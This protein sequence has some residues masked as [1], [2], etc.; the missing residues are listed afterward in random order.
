MNNV[1]FQKVTLI[2]FVLSSVFGSNP[3]L[4]QPMPDKSTQ[5]QVIND[6]SQPHL[7]YRSIAPLEAF[8][9]DLPPLPE[10]SPAAG[11]KVGQEGKKLP[12]WIEYFDFDHS[13]K[14]MPP[15]G[16]EGSYVFDLHLKTD[17]TLYGYRLF[18][19]VD[20]QGQ[21]VLRNLIHF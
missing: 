13:L 11:L 6:E 16:S 15:V 9:I 2:L 3:A 8:I 17:T 5:T 4:A 20:P 7:L 21:P 1:F 10:G 19:K 14:G 12:P 18:L